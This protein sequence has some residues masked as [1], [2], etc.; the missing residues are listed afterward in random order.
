MWSHRLIRHAIRRD[1]YDLTSEDYRYAQFRKTVPN[2]L[3]QLVHPIVIGVSNSQYPITTRYMTDCIL[4]AT[5]QPLLLFSLCLPLHAVLVAPPTELSSGPLSTLSIP[6]SALLQLLPAR[7]HSASPSTP[8]LNIADLALIFIGLGLVAIEAKADG[9]MFKY[10]TSK[11]SSKSK[12]IVHPPKLTNSKINGPSP[13]PYPRSHHPGFITTGMWKWSRHP[14]F[15]AEQLFWVNQALFV[16]AAGR[17]SGV[18]R[19]GWVG[20]AVF[21]PCFAVSCTG[22]APF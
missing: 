16:V 19:S 4:P 18:S 2:W 11:H 7:F 9:E 20:G 21:G 6:Y 12:D 13:K 8:I 3:F 1:F 15:M 22:H 14:N 5:A 10:Q 17:S